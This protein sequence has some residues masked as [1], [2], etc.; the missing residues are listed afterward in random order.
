MPT[1]SPKP[2]PQ[3]QTVRIPA[4]A[5]DVRAIRQ[6]AERTAVAAE[7]IAASLERIAQ[8]IRGPVYGRGA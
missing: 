4:A 1:N 5:E 3:T 6:S 8:A 7:S 2:E